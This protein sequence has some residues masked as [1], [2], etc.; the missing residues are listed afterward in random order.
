[1]S[2]YKVLF[3]SLVEGEAVRL[4][5]SIQVAS[6]KREI[7]R[8]LS[9]H[10]KLMLELGMPFKGVLTVTVVEE[11]EA[12]KDTVYEFKIAPRNKAGFEIL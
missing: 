5:T 6:I 2:K 11:G 8:Q 12:L 9:T 7:Q 4:K 3:E 10:K 1:M